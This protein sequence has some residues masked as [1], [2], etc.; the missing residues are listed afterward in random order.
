MLD[1]YIYNFYIFKYIVYNK[2][3]IIIL[4]ISILFLL[5]NFFFIKVR[6]EFYKTRYNL[7]VSLKFYYII[8][9]I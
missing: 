9:S 8:I 4:I 3:F 1:F 5:N 6:L 2:E 7:L